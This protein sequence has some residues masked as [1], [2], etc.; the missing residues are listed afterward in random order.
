[1]PDPRR[2]SV[3]MPEHLKG[4]HTGTPD[5]IEEVERGIRDAHRNNFRVGQ[6]HIVL[7]SEGDDAF[8]AHLM[9]RTHASAIRNFHRYKDAII[10]VTR[11]PKAPRVTVLV[12]PT[13]K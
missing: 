12:S 6:M 11:D 4:C 8:M 2:P 1:M 3:A 5:I 10:S 13:T 7:N 9:F